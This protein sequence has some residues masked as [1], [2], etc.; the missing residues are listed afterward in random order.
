MGM[1]QQ[2][3]PGGPRPPT[4]ALAGM[5]LSSGPSGSSSTLG[6][7]GAGGGADLRPSTSGSDAGKK[8]DKEKKKRNIFGIK[9]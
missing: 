1:G 4:K 2:M 8:K 3:P 6:V 5:T 9:K 7:A